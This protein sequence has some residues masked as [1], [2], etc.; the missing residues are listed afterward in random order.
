MKKS[1]EPLYKQIFTHFR[2]RI[3]SNE[4]SAGSRLPSENDI[5][6]TF[7][8]S[9]IT[10]SRALA[11]LERINLI[12]RIKGSGSYVTDGVFEPKDGNAF[13]GS[14]SFISLVLPTKGDFASDILKG[15]E[16]IASQNGFFVTFHNSAESPELEKE[17]V[18][19]II[20]RGTRGIIVYPLEPS[21]NMDIFS[22]LLINKY[23]FVLI[24]RNIPG[25]EASL[26]WADNHKAFYGITEYL[27]K[28]GHTRIAFLGTS[29]FDVSSETERYKGFCAAHIKSGVPIM[30][31]NLYGTKDDFRDIPDDY[32]RGQDQNVRA[33]NFFFDTLEKMD[34]TKRPTA[35]AAVNDRIAALLISTAI[36][37]GISIPGDYSITGF[38]NLPFA[39]HLPVPLTTVAQP[40][41]QIGRLAALELFERIRNRN[42]VPQIKTVDTELVIRASAAK[43]H[44]Q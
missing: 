18:D 13:S 16:E 37:R 9:R 29:V 23:P 20:N 35:I 27:L 8:V 31:R 32:M 21:A 14:P 12:Y 42:I 2:D 17:I 26:V 33:A 34:S 38:D 28:Q 41:M 1:S 19:E 6:K 24:D 10:A 36:S 11:E 30:N 39:G 44:R 3:V 5:S 43:P 7:N 4:I 15:V 40:A 25:L 22:R